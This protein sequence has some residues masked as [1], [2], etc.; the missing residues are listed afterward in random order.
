[1]ENENEKRNTFFAHENR[2]KLPSKGA[3][4]SLL[5]NFSYNATVYKTVNLGNDFFSRIFLIK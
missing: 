2:K 5:N 4:F 3:Y 1:M